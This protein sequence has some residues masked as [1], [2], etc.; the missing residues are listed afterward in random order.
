MHLPKFP[1]SFINKH[2]RSKRTELSPLMLLL[3][4]QHSGILD[5]YKQLSFSALIH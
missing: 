5:C 1:G 4:E 2:V 3:F